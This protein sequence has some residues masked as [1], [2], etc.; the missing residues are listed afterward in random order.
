VKAKAFIFIILVSSIFICNMGFAQD[1]EDITLTT[2][3][4]AP[5]GEYGTLSSDTLTVGLSGSA[6]TDSGVL[7]LKPRSSAPGAPNLEGDIYYHDGTGA[8]A[9]GLYYYDYDSASTSGTWE[10]TGGASALPAGMI[11]PFAMSS[12]PTGWLKCDG[13]EVSRTTYAALSLAIGEIYGAG[14]GTTTFNVPDYRGLFLRGLNDGRT[15][16]LADPDASGRTGGDAVGSTQTDMYMGHSHSVNTGSPSQSDQIKALHVGWSRP[17]PPNYPVPKADAGTVTG[18]SGG[19][20]TRPK[21]IYVM[22]CI[23]Y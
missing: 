2:Y 14:D 21:N 20:E 15:D 5:H 11:A 22:Y 19:S 12:V 4:P 13:A 17:R 10:N 16:T 1:T 8:R 23:K 6:A 3:Y 7:N 9:E 18:A